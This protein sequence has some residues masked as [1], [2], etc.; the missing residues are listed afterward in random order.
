MPDYRYELRRGDDLIATGHLTREQPLEVGDRISIGTSSGIVRAVDP[1]L[2]ERELHLVVRRGSVVRGYCGVVRGCRR[3]R[4][5]RRPRCGARLRESDHGR[6]RSVRCVVDQRPC[7]GRASPRFSRDT[8]SGSSGASAVGLYPI[9]ATIQKRWLRSITC[10]TSGQTCSLVGATKKRAWS[11]RTASYSLV[12]SVIRS[13]QVS[14]A[15]SQIQSPIGSTRLKPS[16]TSFT[17]SLT[18]RNKAWFVAARASRSYRSEI[19]MQPPIC[20]PPDRPGFDSRSA[21]P[22]GGAVLRDERAPKGP[23]LGLAIS[24]AGSLNSFL[25]ARPACL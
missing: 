20:V 24:I 11:R 4:C 13:A 7:V 23:R 10:S 6:V 16:F 21:P 14:L 2:H 9:F 18:S 17:R 1:V 8:R 15:H 12:D 3:R 19:D 25:A 22:L 5:S